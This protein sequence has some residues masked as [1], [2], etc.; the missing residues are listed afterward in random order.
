M[1]GAKISCFSGPSRLDAAPLTAPKSSFSALIS[2]VCHSQSQ[3]QAW[4]EHNIDMDMD[5]SRSSRVLHS[6][7][8]SYATNFSAHATSP[9]P[10]SI[11][12]IE[13]IKVKRPPP[14]T[15]RRF[16]RFFTPRS[17]SDRSGNASSQGRSGRQLRDITANAI[18]RRAADQSHKASGL[19][20]NGLDDENGDVQTPRPSKR[21]KL[22]S[23]P[24]Q[25]SP[26]QSSP[27]KA[28]PL[29]ALEEEV[30]R[31]SKYESGWNP[32]HN[33]EES[34]PLPVR[35]SRAIAKVRYPVPLLMSTPHCSP[36]IPLR[37]NF[38]IDTKNHAHCAL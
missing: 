8:S 22:I 27:L 25:S 21:R 18:N 1:A 37:T 17:S 10:P 14:I 34:F 16:T 38:P 28:P 36:Y 30:V 3:R 12:S 9:P 15:P 19:F 5:N 26:I 32:Q 35:K 31:N 7:S 24:P 11:E 4:E 13:S 33:E 6:R 23:P 29:C 2:Y 20:T